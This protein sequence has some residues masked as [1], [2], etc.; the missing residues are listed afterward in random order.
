M[1]SSL[2]SEKFAMLSK[3]ECSS[4]AGDDG[5]LRCEVCLRAGECEERGPMKS[6]KLS[7]APGRRTP[8]LEDMDCLI[9]S[10]LSVPVVPMSSP[11]TVHS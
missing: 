4:Y 7:L 8:E 9:P 11:K 5:G 1:T 6:R 2:P 10:S 3:E